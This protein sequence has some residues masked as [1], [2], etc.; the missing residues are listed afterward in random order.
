MADMSAP[1][2]INSLVREARP[3]LVRFLAR[4]V[5]DADAEDVAQAVL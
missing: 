2:E 3:A 1:F 5:G 4:I